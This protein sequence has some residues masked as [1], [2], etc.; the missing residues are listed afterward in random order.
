[1]TAGLSGRIAVVTGAGRMRSIGR[2]IAQHLAH[3]GVDVVLIGTGR[4]PARGAEE[5]AADWRDIESVADDV[6]AAGARALTVTADISD[7]ASVNDIFQR[8]IAE[9]GSAPTILVNNAAASRGSDRVS[10]AEL[11]VAE[12]DTVMRVNLRGTFLMSRAF[13]RLV[14]DGT[15]AGIINISSIGGK[16]SGPF[17]AAY[18]ASKAAIQSLTSSMAKELGARGIRVN[19]ICPGVVDT[20]RLGDRTPEQ[21]AEYVSATIPMARMGAP[22]DIADA[23]LFL[24]SDAASWVT[25]QSL[26]VDGGQ[27]TIR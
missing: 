7:E 6:R 26:N 3:A 10:V 5:I 8:V 23:A 25:G 2:G 11:D 16:L 1:M 13:V 14:P 27:L 18:S 12:W 15:P 19:A 17:T 9:W 20:S 4:E 21:W 22:D 24:L